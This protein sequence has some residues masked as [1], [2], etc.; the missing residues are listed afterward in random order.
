[1]H[2]DRHG[3]SWQMASS[4]DPPTSEIDLNGDSSHMSHSSHSM[5]DGESPF[6][7]PTGRQRLPQNT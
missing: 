3:Q 1:M 4:S 7:A 2:I 5:E 6:Q